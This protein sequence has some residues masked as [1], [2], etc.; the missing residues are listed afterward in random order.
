MAEKEVRM[1]EKKGYDP[2]SDDDVNGA[3]EAEAPVAKDCKPC[4]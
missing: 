3:G 1:S 2:F 4:G